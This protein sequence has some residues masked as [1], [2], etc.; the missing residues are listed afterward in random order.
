MLHSCYSRQNFIT[1]KKINLT[2]DI[3]ANV[4][5]INSS[6]KPYL[7]Y[8]QLYLSNDKLIKIKYIEYENQN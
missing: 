3:V 1:T 7:L 5:V 2:I 8:L 4:V 6:N